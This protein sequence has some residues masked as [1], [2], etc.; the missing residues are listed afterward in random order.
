MKDCWSEE[1]ISNIIHKLKEVKER[2]FGSI[3]I[4]FV[5][6]TVVEINSDDVITQRVFKRE[7]SRH[8]PSI[9]YGFLVNNSNINQVWGTSPFVF[10]L[11]SNNCKFIFV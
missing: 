7:E 9:S 2:H 11:F 8:S 1:N 6:L 4:T 3:D 10:R 5:V